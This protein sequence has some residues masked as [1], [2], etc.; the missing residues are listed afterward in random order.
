M[1]VLVSIFLFLVCLAGLELYFISFVAAR[2]GLFG[3]LALVLGTGILG[4]FVA[5]KNAK[6]AIT[7][8]MQGDFR[9]G[10][11]ERQMFDAIVFFIAAALLIIPGILTDFAG[12]ILLFPGTRSALYGKFTGGKVTVRTSGG[13]T[14]SAYENRE[15]GANC[16]Y[17][18]GDDDVI[19]ISAED[20]SRDD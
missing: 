8:L 3:T 7:N 17:T 9:S 12:L 13:D 18:L 11:P 10:P 15:R 1:Q 19:D 4:A 6:L 2:L 5:R 20:I 14:S 16:N